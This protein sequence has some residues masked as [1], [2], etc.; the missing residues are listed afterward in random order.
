MTEPRG[1]EQ[2]TRP[3]EPAG[4]Y[5]T[6]DKRGYFTPR[7]KALGLSPESIDHLVFNLK[8]MDVEIVRQDIE[9]ALE[10]ARGGAA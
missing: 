7:L 10:R 5:I 8:W 2:S 9:R 1:E 4:Q 3:F 6:Q